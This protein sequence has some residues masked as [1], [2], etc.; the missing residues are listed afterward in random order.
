LAFHDAD[1]QWTSTVPSSPDPTYN[2]GEAVDSSLGDFLSRPVKVATYSWILGNDIYQEVDPWTAF[3]THPSVAKKLDN[4]KFLRCN[5]SVKVVI[6]STA[7]HYSKAIVSYLPLTAYDE[8]DK[9]YPGTYLNNVKLS[10]RPHIFLDAALSQGGCLCIP[11]MNNRNWIKVTSATQIASLGRVTLSS[12]D[13]LK[14]ASGG[15]TNVNITVFVW[16]TD[17]KVCMPT[18][19]LSAQSDEFGTGIVSKPASAVAAISRSLESV[20]IIAPFAKATTMIASAIGGVARLFGFSRPNII[21][22]T[23]LMKNVVL[24]N[25]ANCDA[26]E[27]AFKLTVDSKQELSI[28]PRISGLDNIDE[29]TIPYITSKMSYLTHFPWTLA[30]ASDTLL[31]N[32]NVTPIMADSTGNAGY[33]MMP[34]CFASLPFQNWSGS[35]IYRFQVVSSSFHRGRIKICWDPQ[36]GTVS[37]V[38]DSYNRV[39][40]RIVD[41]SQE[42][43]FEIQI[44]WGSERAYLNTGPLTN[45]TSNWSN[46]DTLTLDT[47]LHNGRLSVWIVNELVAPA[48]IADIS[49]N[50]FVRAANNFRLRNPTG[51]YIDRL[52]V[53]EPQSSEFS[54]TSQENAPEVASTA[55]NSLGGADPD[56]NIDLVYF[57]ECINSFRTLLR[58]YNRV[59]TDFIDTTPH[60]TKEGAIAMFRSR[61]FPLYRGLTANGVDD[62]LTVRQN[63]N[64]NT[65]INYLT[66]AY[67]SRR[68]GIRYKMLPNTFGLDN[69]SMIEADR[70]SVVDVPDTQVTASVYSTTTPSWNTL[71]TTAGTTN[72]MAGA[73]ITSATIQPGLE[74]EYPFYNPFRYAYAR[75]TSLEVGTGEDD[76]DRDFKRVFVYFLPSSAPSGDT[77]IL[78]VT[79]YV[80]TG[81]D[82]QLSYFVDVPYMWYW[83]GY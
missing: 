80:A 76:S 16:A 52:T 11:Y 62:I 20:P 54:G 2:Q 66:P 50:V 28:D 63:I 59:R 78:G 31:W 32:C 21:T 8:I 43:D 56:S 51:E 35:M 70:L 39:Y 1:E 60:L 82:F 42:K 45:S 3:L 24:G 36:S 44:D 61:V 27:V 55:I 12:M 26:A 23:S 77:S 5:L 81:E 33:A 41:I 46:L 19:S 7:F 34:V 9:Y 47:S 40:T 64:H 13:V 75:R 38:P 14:H 79:S 37:N 73:Y 29:L 83:N 17:V 30:A 67:L 18:L 48:D 53:F 74:I 10:Q 72:G 65:L 25:I 22:D 4:F 6:N 49:I 57:G 71:Q 15:T 69:I 58:R 68:G